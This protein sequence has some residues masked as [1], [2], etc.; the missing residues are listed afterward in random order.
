MAVYASPE[1]LK[2]RVGNARTYIRP[3]QRDSD[4]D[5]IDTSVDAVSVPD[6]YYYIYM[7]I[8]NVAP[9]RVLDMWR[10]ISP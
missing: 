8:Y 2:Q 3:I 5:P 7:I 6:V 9:E 1:V 4:L 10:E